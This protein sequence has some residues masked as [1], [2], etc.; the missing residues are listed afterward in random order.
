MR[1]E[2]QEQQEEEDECEREACG[3]EW[4]ILVEELSELEQKQQH[5][6]GIFPPSVAADSLP[7]L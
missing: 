3:R 1:R 5:I 2:E 7:P 6:R 4:M